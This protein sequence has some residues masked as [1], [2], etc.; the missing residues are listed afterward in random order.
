MEE[1]ALYLFRSAL[2]ITGFTFVWV[3]FLRNENFFLLKRIYLITGILAS[4]LFPLITIRYA[5]EVPFEGLKSAFAPVTELQEAALPSSGKKMNPLFFLYFAGVA[6]FALRLIWHS[7]SLYRI[8]IKSGSDAKDGKVILS[9]GNSAP[10][11]FF[12]YIFL[13]PELTGGGL[14][15]I[16]NH[17]MAH[18][19][20]KHWIDLVLV[21]L[22]CI[23]QWFNPVVWIYKCFIRQNHEYLADREALRKSADPA[24]YKA[25]LLSQL[26]GSAVLPLTN[27]FI[28]TLSKKRFDMMKKTSIHPIRKFR[29]L[30]LIPV[31]AII[32]W[33]CSEPL[34]NITD[35]VSLYD[36]SAPP[37][38]SFSEEN[39]PLIFVDE[40]EISYEEMKKI[41]PN[42]I[43]SLTV[44]FLYFYKFS[45][46]TSI[47][48]NSLSFVSF[49]KILR[50]F[51]FF[52]IPF[53]FKSCNLPIAF[54]NKINFLLL[55]CSPKMH[56]SE[57]VF[58]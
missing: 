8:A 14:R 49:D 24:F 1:F 7:T 2:W 21:E 40:L 15:E 50:K 17:E 11:S 31:I 5:V 37:S 13:N 10:F 54:F 6:M 35:P 38:T 36:E 27:P 4:F 52:S 46:V 26:L 41:N 53:K 18:I 28:E 32:F 39:L 22:L 58:I 25:T 45:K 16:I 19:R 51:S 20:Q 29:L 34:Y 33:F 44:S 42:E 48:Y 12:G 47:N 56:F 3:V 23:L 55:F 30:P 43:E 9:T 57:C